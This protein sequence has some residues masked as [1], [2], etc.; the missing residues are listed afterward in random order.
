MLNIRLRTA[1][2]IEI[3]ATFR[4][5]ILRM[6]TYIIA[7]S[8]RKKEHHGPREPNSIVQWLQDRLVA[9]GVPTHA[10]FNKT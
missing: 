10:L 4:K 8:E 1:R 6:C 9:L 5:N 2:Q 7:F 3:I